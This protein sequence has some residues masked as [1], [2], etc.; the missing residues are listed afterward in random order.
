MGAAEWEDAWR[1]R[2]KEIHFNN[3]CLHLEVQVGHHLTVGERFQPHPGHTNPVLPRAPCEGCRAHFEPGRR[4]PLLER[5]M[6]EC[7]EGGCCGGPRG[8]GLH[9]QLAEMSHQ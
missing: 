1:I 2:R 4:I 6:T 3:L 5:L 8:W 9:F 7:H